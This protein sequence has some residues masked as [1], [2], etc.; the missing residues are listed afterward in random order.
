[1]YATVNIPALV[2]PRL[3]PHRNVDAAQREGAARAPD[4]LPI[5]LATCVLDPAP[6]I[7]PVTFGL[8]PIGVKVIERDGIVHLMDWVGE[9]HY[10]TPAAFLD[11]AATMGISRRLPGT[12]IATRLSPGESRLLLVHKH[13]WMAEEVRQHTLLNEPWYCPHHDVDHEAGACDEGVCSGAWWHSGY[14]RLS[15]TRPGI[16]LSVPITG[17]DVIAGNPASQVR[18][19]V[20]RNIPGARLVTG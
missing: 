4:R 11:E 18:Y 2:V 9:E 16:F 13:A 8:S 6:A 20:L 5:A 14:A 12:T 10:P 1:V 3:I 19:N 7:D 15:N 17:I